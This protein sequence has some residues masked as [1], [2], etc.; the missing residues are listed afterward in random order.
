MTTLNTNTYTDKLAE[1][2]ESIKNSMYTFEVT[3][4]CNYSTFVTVYK[5]ETLA[6]LYNRIILHFGGIEIDRLYF[7]SSEGGQINIPLSKKPVF[8]F[9]RDNILTNP[10]KW[11]PVYPVPAPIVY[12]IYLDDG[13]CHEHYC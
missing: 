5:D 13:H 8:Q 2:I 7:I 1:Y 9:V 12:R 11:V 4:C 10:I 6:D 3:K